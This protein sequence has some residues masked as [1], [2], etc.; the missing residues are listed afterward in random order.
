[1]QF[2]QTFSAGS[3]DTLYFPQ[4]AIGA[5]TNRLRR[6]SAAMQEHIFA[7][8]HLPLLHL[9]SYTQIWSKTAKTP[10]GLETELAFQLCFERSAEIHS[11]EGD[12]VRVSSVRA[13]R[14][15][16]LVCVISIIKII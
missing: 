16:K 5:C 14:K 11:G 7:L 1:M 6:S 10:R 15:A 4:E 2:G 13:P 9:K 8:R 12:R 3:Q